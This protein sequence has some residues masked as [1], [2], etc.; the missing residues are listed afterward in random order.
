MT[1]TF[2]PKF[3]QHG[4]EAA[5]LVNQAIDHLDLRKKHLQNDERNRRIVASILAQRL[6]AFVVSMSVIDKADRETVRAVLE[7]FAGPILTRVSGRSTYA[8]RE[9]YR[10]SAA[11]F[12]TTKDTSLKG[13]QSPSVTTAFGTIY[14]DGSH[15]EV[16]FEHIKLVGFVKPSL[17][18]IV[19]PHK[20]WEIFLGDE[21]QPSAHWRELTESETEHPDH[22]QLMDFALKQAFMM[23]VPMTRYG[24]DGFI[25]GTPDPAIFAIDNAI[26]RYSGRAGQ[27]PLM[28]I[29]DSYKRQHI[30][31]GGK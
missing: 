24:S 5:Q 16:P 28:E 13:R 26:S 21:P 11:K 7:G 12:S 19:A 15:S 4:N 6:G 8:L 31:W 30:R 9:E 23:G 1:T 29:I 20:H 3:E 27:R 10:D 25:T 14:Q 17:V 18:R 2:Y 22:D